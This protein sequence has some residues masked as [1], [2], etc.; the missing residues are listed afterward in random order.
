MFA[1]AGSVRNLRTAIRATMTLIGLVIIMVAAQAQTGSPPARQPSPQG[2]T[3]PVNT[4]SGGAPAA[5]PQG[6]TPPAMQAAPSGS[7]GNVSNPA[8]KERER[9]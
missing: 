9:K 3:G 6:D 1:M 7:S 2:D 4:G 5:S 8:A